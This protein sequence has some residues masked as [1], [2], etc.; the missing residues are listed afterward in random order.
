[1]WE[2]R[3]DEA[4]LYI[5]RKVRGMQSC[6]GWPSNEKKKYVCDMYIYI[7]ERILSA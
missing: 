6:A 5:Q 3:R 1:M 7:Y 4:A 2:E